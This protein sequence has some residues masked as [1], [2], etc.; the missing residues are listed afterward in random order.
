LVRISH[1]R[2]TMST[3]IELDDHLT[4]DH[5]V[6]NELHIAWVDGGVDFG[7]TGFFGIPSNSLPVGLTTPDDT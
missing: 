1:E 5:E 3:T 2:A 7:L 4:R 6:R